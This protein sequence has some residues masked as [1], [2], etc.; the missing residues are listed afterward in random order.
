M[1]CKECLDKTVLALKS[2]TN[3]DP[4]QCDCNQCPYDYGSEECQNL[5]RAALQII[6]TNNDRIAELEEK[7]QGLMVNSMI[8][9]HIQTEINRLQSRDEDAGELTVGGIA[10]EYLDICGEECS[11]D[12]SVGIQPCPYWNPPDVGAFGE[13]LPCGCE[14]KNYLEEMKDETE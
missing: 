11:G 2:C 7:I 1:N 5:C 6:T 13:P 9:E 8:Q 4:G 14:L 3:L 10:S 12:K